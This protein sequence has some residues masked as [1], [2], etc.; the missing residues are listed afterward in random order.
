MLDE[1]NRTEGEYR[2]EQSLQELFE[3]QAARNPERVALVFEDA[4][5]SYGELNRKANQLAHYL[6]KREVG[7]E[8]LVGVCMARSPALVVGL[9]G[10]LKAGGA[11]V[12]LDPS[13]PPE[14]VSL[15]I[16]DARIKVLLTQSHLLDGLQDLNLK[17]VPSV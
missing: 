9:L 1:W 6:K 2:R 4:E 3:E 7:P 12:P 16:D 11:Y 15:M 8:V 5:L 13:S 10:I 14:R 17:V